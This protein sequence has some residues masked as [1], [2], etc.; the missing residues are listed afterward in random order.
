MKNILRQLSIV[1]GVLILIGA[2]MFA[3]K[4]S[5]QKE[6]PK[7]KETTVEAAPQVEV[8]AVQ[9]AT[10]ASSIPIQGRLEAYNKTRIFSEVQGVLKSSDRPFKIGTYFPKGSILLNIDQEETRLNLLAQR[11]A[12]MNAITMMMPDLKIDYP[13]SFDQWKSYLDQFDVKQSLRTFPE[14]LNDQEKYFI[15]NRNLL[16]QY[17]SIKSLETR[18]GKYVVTAPF[19]GVLTQANVTAGSLVSPGQV[20]GELMNSSNYELAAT[21]QLADLKHIQVGDKVTL[22]SDDINDSWKGSVKRINN[23]VDPMTQSVTVYINVNGKNLREGMYLRGEVAANSINNAIEVPIELV[24]LDT[25][26]TYVVKED[27]LVKQ[28]VDILQERGT[29]VVLAGLENGTAILKNRLVNAFEG[30]EVKVIED[31][32]ISELD[33]KN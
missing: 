29:T 21:A 28:T 2:G 20:L 7:E 10:I 16:N 11:S 27:K 30:M 33:R 17:Y 5:E 14:P 12:L 13:T 24:D 22:T 26:T 19:S 18:L 9:N 4:L 31:K 25:K 32:S 23:Q 15:A 1:A 6:P 8:I 3:R